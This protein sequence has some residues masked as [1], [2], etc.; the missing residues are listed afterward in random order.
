MRCQQFVNDR[1][2]FLVLTLVF[3]ILWIW[4]LLDYWIWALVIFWIWRLYIIYFWN[5]SL[6]VYLDIYIYIYMKCRVPPGDSGYI[7]ELPRKPQIHYNPYKFFEIHTNMN[8]MIH[9]P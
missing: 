8:S 2:F 9:T 5:D 3:V 7:Q 4:V 6:Y 1:I